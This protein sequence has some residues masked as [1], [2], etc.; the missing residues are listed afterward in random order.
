MD[1]Q[2]LLKH[3]IEQLK[4]NIK[5]NK[6]LIVYHLNEVLDLTIKDR[7]RLLEKWWE[8]AEKSCKEIA[9][10]ELIRKLKEE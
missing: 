5:W 3:H 1:K 9:A 8:E 2:A 6:T 4:A 7:L 10:S